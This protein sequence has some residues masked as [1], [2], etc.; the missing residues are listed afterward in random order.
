[1][2]FKQV[3]ASSAVISVTLPRERALD[4]AQILDIE[5]FKACN[6]CVVGFKQEHSVVYKTISGEHKSWTAEQQRN[7]E[8]NRYLKLQT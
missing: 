3:T 7:G 8:R 5:Y 6:V 2:W 1:M 4:S